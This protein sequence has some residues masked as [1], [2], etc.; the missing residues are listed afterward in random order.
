M[1]ASRPGGATA[2]VVSR[3][4]LLRAW[5][6]HH[7]ALLFST[8]GDLLASP[9]SSV[10]AWLMIG[11]AMALPAILFL[12]L[13]ALATVSDG[14]GGTPRVSVYLQETVDAS[15][16]A[17]MARQLGRLPGVAGA[18]FI[19]RSEALAE[20]QQQSGFGDALATL[21]RNPLPHVV[22]LALDATLPAAGQR[23]VKR[24]ERT[25]GVDG[26]TLDLIWLERLHAFLALGQRLTAALAL[27]LGAGLALVMGNTIRLAIFSRRQE[28][29]VV[30]LVGGTDAFVRR[31]FLYLGFWYGLGGALTALA[32]TALAARFLAAPVELLA[33]GYGKGLFALAVPPRLAAMLLGAGVALG[34]LGASLAVR[35][36]LRDLDG[37]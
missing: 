24:L 25:K 29:E 36:H 3:R 15:E 10:M 13:S 14:W 35:R 21:G 5:A 1:A 20:F 33:L 18:R 17:L 16:G 19:S 22:E 7:R 30:K 37:R 26:V 6:L 2:A 4:D 27:A 8:L 31:P 9:L 32:L 28:I 12:L 34:L 23:L 11:I